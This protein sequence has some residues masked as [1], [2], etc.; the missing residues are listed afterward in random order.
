MGEV[1]GYL[2]EGDGLADAVVAHLFAAEGGEEGTAVEGEAEVACNAADIGALATA[3]AEIELGQVVGDGAER[4]VVEVMGGL[5]G[6]GIGLMGGCAVDGV[7]GFGDGAAGTKVGD[8]EV[9][10]LDGFGGGKRRFFAFGSLTGIAVG[11]LASYLD[12]AEDGR[13]LLDGT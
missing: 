5:G 3:D 10:D 13:Y 7:F 2:V 9:V 12:S 4:V 8:L 6:L 1:G 11:A